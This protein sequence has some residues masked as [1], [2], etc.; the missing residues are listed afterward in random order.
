MTRVTSFAPSAMGRALSIN[1]RRAHSQSDRRCHPSRAH[2]RSD[3]A[4]NDDAEPLPSPPVPGGD[5]ISQPPYGDWDGLRSRR[6]TCS[7]T[8][9]RSP[10][11]TGWKP[12]GQADPSP[13]RDDR[14]AS[15][16]RW[17]PGAPTSRAWSL[18]GE[19]RWPMRPGRSA[20]GGGR[21]RA[22]RRT[23]SRRRPVP[24][25][26]ELSG[27]VGWSAAPRQ[28]MPYA[29]AAPVRLP[30]HREI[31]PFLAR[32]WERTMGRVPHPRGLQVPSEESTAKSAGC[33]RGSRLDPEFGKDAG[34]VLAGRLWAN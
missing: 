26:R 30:A 14:A 10:S 29:H 16:V 33:S 23:S 8:T 24:P 2:E 31:S 4:S 32:L 15:L 22:P 7:P 28:V 20:L 3:P 27:C 17:P 6:T 12:L 25:E 19:P 34:D 13:A 18:P 1:G 5:P 11:G 21:R 9:T